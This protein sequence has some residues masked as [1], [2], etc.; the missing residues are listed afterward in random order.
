MRVTTV[1]GAE[2]AAA[3]A[4]E[5]VDRLIA[6]A[7]DARGVAHVAL[8][9]GSTPRRCHELLAERRSAWAGVHLWASDERCVPPDD[10]EA[11]WK[12][13]VE[14]LVS[15]IEIDEAQLHRPPGELGPDDG[16][17]A[18]E[19]GRR[20]PGPAHPPVLDVVMC[21][22]GEDG[23]TLSLF[24]G[25]PEVEERSRLPPGG[26]GSPKPPPRPPPFPPP[27]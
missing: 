18:H 8:A 14:S 4:A 19:R 23:H 5:N 15:R 9:G 22:L 21:G 20:A 3:R 25:H 7:L 26:G 13:V 27:P 2:A 24:P 12:M 1:R 10:D 6:E 17:A 16:A 11:N